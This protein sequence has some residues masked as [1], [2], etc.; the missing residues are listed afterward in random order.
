MCLLAAG[1]VY[2]TVAAELMIV[3]NRSSTI[4]A[5]EAS[6]GS[7]AKVTAKALTA[8]RARPEIIDLR[9]IGIYRLEGS[10]RISTIAHPSR[11]GLCDHWESANDEHP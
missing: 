5:V 1:I 2:L 6:I 7:L 4:Q 8:I 11:L 10:S 3:D 9:C